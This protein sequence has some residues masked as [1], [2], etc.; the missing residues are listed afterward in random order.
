[1]NYWLKKQLLLNEGTRITRIKRICTDLIRE[2]LQNLRY[3]RAIK[4]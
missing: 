4:T 1:M 2:D 3:Q